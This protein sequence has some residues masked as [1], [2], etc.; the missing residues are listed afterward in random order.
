VAEST[1]QCL[2]AYRKFTADHPEYDVEVKLCAFTPL[3]MQ[4]AAKVFDNVNVR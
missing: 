1:K 4:E 2:L 3:E